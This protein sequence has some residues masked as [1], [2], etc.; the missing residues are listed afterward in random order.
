MVW[1]AATSTSYSCAATISAAGDHGRVAATSLAVRKDL[2][3]CARL[4]G[5]VQ[6]FGR[7]DLALKAEIEAH[8][9]W[10]TAMDIHPTRDVIVTAAEDCTLNVWQ[11]PLGGRRV[12]ALLSICWITC[13]ITGVAFCG[14]RRDDIAAVAYDTDEIQVWRASGTIS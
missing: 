2:I 10:I 4:S 13:P 6:I 1:E 5:V 8:S 7:R 11:L 3:V 14:P 12:A 9:R